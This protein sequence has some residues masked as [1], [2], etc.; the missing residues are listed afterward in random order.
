MRCL[1]R[2]VYR[3]LQSDLRYLTGRAEENHAALI[4]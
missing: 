3:S 1:A 2:H 4:L